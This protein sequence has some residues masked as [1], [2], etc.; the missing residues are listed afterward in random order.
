VFAGEFAAGAA[1]FKSNV[2]QVNLGLVGLASAALA[3]TPKGQLVHPFAY[4][5]A[6]A[7]QFFS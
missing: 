5:F 7:G 6:R 3:F 1:A 4:P 2:Y